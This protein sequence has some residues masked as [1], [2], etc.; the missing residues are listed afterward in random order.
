MHGALTVDRCEKHVWDRVLDLHLA[1]EYAGVTDKSGYVYLSVRKKRRAV[2]RLVM[3]RHLGRELLPTEEVHHKNGQRSDN[4]L[5]QLELWSHSQ[6][7]GQ[8]VED[9]VAWAIELLKLYAPEHLADE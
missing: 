3:E 6:P 9:K 7:C 1:G 5:E 2:H 4:R 8:R